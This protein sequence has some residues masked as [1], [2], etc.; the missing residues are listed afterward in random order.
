MSRASLYAQL[1]ELPSAL[2]ARVCSR[3]TSFFLEAQCVPG[4]HWLIVESDNSLGRQPKFSGQEVGA[5][6]PAG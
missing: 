5:I 4:C 1:L 2:A 6:L 3:R